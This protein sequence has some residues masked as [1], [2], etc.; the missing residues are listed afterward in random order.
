MY[1][2]GTGSS[3]KTRRVRIISIPVEW[4]IDFI[5]SGKSYMK[6]INIPKDYKICG[7]YYNHRRSGFEFIIESQE[8]EEYEIGAEI[9]YLAVEMERRSQN[10]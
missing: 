9:P 7:V 8:F 6:I 10:V 5:T 4:M 3:H 1:T 2:N